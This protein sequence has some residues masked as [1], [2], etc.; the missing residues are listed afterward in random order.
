M[1]MQS[2]QGDSYSLIQD[3]ADNSVDFLCTDPPYHLSNTKPIEDRLKELLRSFFNIKFPNFNQGDVQI[4][5]YSEL[6]SIFRDC[7]ELTWSQGG[8]VRKESWIGASLK[9][10]NL[11]FP[12]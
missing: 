12:N 7:P 9:Q 5:Q 3:L 8:T 2:R 11:L 6:V 1:T 10:I 4:S